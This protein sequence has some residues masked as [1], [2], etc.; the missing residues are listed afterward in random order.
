MVVLICQ[1]GGA[2]QSGFHGRLDGAFA[3]LLQADG[4]D[5]CEFHTGS[6]GKIPQL[7]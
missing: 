5:F 2:L 1:V 4:S 6:I 3:D 7:P